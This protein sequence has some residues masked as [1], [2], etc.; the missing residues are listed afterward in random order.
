MLGQYVGEKDKSEEGCCGGFED[1]S[2]DGTDG[3]LE[4]VGNENA[5]LT[6]RCNVWRVGT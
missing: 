5:S 2:V 3:V 1:G 6:G 4:C